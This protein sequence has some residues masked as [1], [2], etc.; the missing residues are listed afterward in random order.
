MFQADKRLITQLP[1]LISHPWL[2]KA[3]L[4]QR[5]VVFPQQ[6]LLSWDSE[7]ALLVSAHVG[8]PESSMTV[9]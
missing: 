5:S 2:K 4:N 7:F 8:G 1:T 6:N 3:I 9:P